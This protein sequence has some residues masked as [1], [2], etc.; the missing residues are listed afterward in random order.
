LLRLSKDSPQEAAKIYHHLNVMGELEKENWSGD[1]KKKIDNN[2]LQLTAGNHRV[3]DG[4][5]GSEIVIFFIC[6][7]KGRR[8][9]P[10]D[11]KRAMLNQE[12]YEEAAKG[13]K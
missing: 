2:N 6:R 3:Y 13:E 4:I 1:W 5:Y 12:R 11:L 9:R 10:K 8:A 7:K